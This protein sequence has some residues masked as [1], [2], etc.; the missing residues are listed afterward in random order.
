L[1]ETEL[2]SNIDVDEGLQPELQ[3]MPMPSGLL[4]AV[5]LV[6]AIAWL[7]ASAWA[8]TPRNPPAKTVT[9]RGEAP[10]ST[11]LPPPL[12]PAVAGLVEQARADLARRHSVSAEAV[13]LVDV[14][15][16]VWPD[17]GLGC[18]RPGVQ[19][20]QVPVDGFLIRLTLEGRVYHYHQGRARPPFLCGP[21]GRR[22]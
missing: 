1:P 21:D 16:V 4:P 11:P 2:E 12:D 13:A 19:Y 22:D 15:G 8:D 6:S 10:G 14:R 20:P 17:A 7:G 5:L 9:E 18:P 3:A